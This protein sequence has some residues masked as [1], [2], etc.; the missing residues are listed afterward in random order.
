MPHCGGAYSCNCVVTGDGV[1]GS[2][3]L[4][5]PYVITSVPEGGGAVDSVNGEVGAVV[6]DAADVGA[7]PAGTAA[8]LVGALVIPDSPDDIGAATA[9]QG[10]KA[11]TAVQPG[12]LVVNVRDFGAVGDGV[13]DDTAAFNAACAAAKAVLVPA[14]TYKILSTVTIPDG[15]ELR[16]AGRK[17]SVLATSGNYTALTT[18]GGEGQAIRDIKITNSFTGT[19]TTHDILIVNPF[20]PLLENVEIALSQASL[21]KGGI[22]I[23]KDLGQP[24]FDKCFMPVLNN[25]L[26]RNGVLYI[27]GVTDVKVNGGWVWGTYTNAPGAVEL[28]GASNCSFKDL[29]IAPSVNAG[30]LVSTGLS[31]LSIAGGLMD[32]NGDPSI[33]PGPGFKSTAWVRGVSL[34]GIKFW[35]LWGSA[36]VFND[37]RNASITGNQFASNNREDVGAADIDVTGGQDIVVVGNTFSAPD[38]RTVKGKVYTEDATS[39]DNI[40]DLN[41]MEYNA[42]AHYY[43]SPLVTLR[44]GSTLGPGNRPDGVWPLSRVLTK[45]ANYTVL[46]EDLFNQMSIHAS[47]TITLTLPSAGS[48]HAGNALPVKNVGTGIVTIN[49]VSSQTIDGGPTTMTLRPGRALT[50]QS[51]STG[52]RIVN[53]TALAPALVPTALAMLATVSATAWPTANLAVFQRFSIQES[54]VYRYANVRLDVASGNWQLAVVR[55]H[56]SGL[57]DY[58]RVMNTGVVAAP[59][60]GDKQ[61][62]LGSTYLPAGEYAMVVW[63]DNTTLKTRYAT[64]SGV[65]STRASAE[66]SGLA[67]GIPASGT[68]AWNST[69]FIGGLTLEADV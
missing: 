5:D 39:T 37:V 23:I 1:S 30:Y 20:H 49:T 42:G 55:L 57:V 19:R 7:D 16:G 64:N 12:D 52:W 38:V 43:A 22:G 48:L 3:T 36:I 32:G 47:G 4:S 44:N 27:S 54:R 53:S 56:G 24:G 28:A 13:A 65:S 10:A 2:G 67:S 61:V 35:K 63:A 11:D 25:I 8:G 29:D 40:V 34:A 51:D 17:A 66:T 59:T 6:L 46:K 14:G 62:D 31:N 26:V 60:A 50:L 41:T 33:H 58:T 15:C 18:V 68:V 69:R 45:S 9:A 21:I